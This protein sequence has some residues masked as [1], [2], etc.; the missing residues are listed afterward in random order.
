MS[1]MNEEKRDKISGGDF[2]F[3]KQ[4]K[5]PLKMRSTFATPLPASTKL[6]V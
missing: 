1:K 5:E 6:R 4:R 2:A 3:P